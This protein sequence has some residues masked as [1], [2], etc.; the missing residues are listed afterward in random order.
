MGPSKNQ[1]SK[2]SH[3]VSDILLDSERIKRESRHSEGLQTVLKSTKV[4][5]VFSPAGGYIHQKPK[6]EENLL[7]SY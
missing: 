2:T 5:P 1:T 6:S 3:N 7:G 4:R